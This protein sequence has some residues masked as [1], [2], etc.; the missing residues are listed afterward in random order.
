M[1]HV[2]YLHGSP[3]VLSASH[4]PAVH[5]HHPVTANDGKRHS[6]LRHQIEQCHYINSHKQRGREAGRQGG[7]EAG[8]QG[9][10]EAGRQGGREGGRKGGREEGREGG[11]EEGREGGREGGSKW[12]REMSTTV[13]LLQCQLTSLCSYLQ[14]TDI[15]G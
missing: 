6:I 4:L 10:R 8:R 15:C 9:G 12:S 2:V 5:L 11:R 7:R 3:G 13:W 14:F 1:L